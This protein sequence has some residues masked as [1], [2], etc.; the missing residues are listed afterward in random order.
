M[1]LLKSIFCSSS[2][3]SPLTNSRR[4]SIVSLSPEIVSSFKHQFGILIIPKDC[5][6]WKI[7]GDGGVSSPNYSRICFLF[8]P[9]STSP[10]RDS[11]LDCV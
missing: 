4:L 5:E 10:N 11:P 6:N 7:G 2:C 3:S 8:Y 1:I 9:Y